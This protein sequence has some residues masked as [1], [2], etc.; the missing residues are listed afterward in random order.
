[1]LPFLLLPATT[2]PLVLAFLPTAGWTHAVTAILPH[3]AHAQPPFLL[4]VPHSAAYLRIDVSLVRAACCAHLC[5]L[6]HCWFALPFA[7]SPHCPVRHAPHAHNYMPDHHRPVWF[8]GVR[9]TCGVLFFRCLPGSDVGRLLPSTPYL[10]GHTSRTVVKTLS[11]LL[12]LSRILPRGSV[13]FSHRTVVS[14]RNY[15]RTISSVGR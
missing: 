7:P 6:L 9:D 8:A 10:S 14:A 3:T 15:Y 4:P 13:H 2:Y 5:Y 1:M 11:S 12:H